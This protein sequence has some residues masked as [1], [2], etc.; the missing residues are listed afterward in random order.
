MG[1]I[2]ARDLRTCFVASVV[3]DGSGAR[4]GGF[5]ATMVYA[6]AGLLEKYAVTAQGVANGGG[7][8]AR[9]APFHF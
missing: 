3:P 4:C 7:A 1:F 8:L 9:T 6:Y 2:A 5:P